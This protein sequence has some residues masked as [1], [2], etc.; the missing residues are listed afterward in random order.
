MLK[1]PNSRPA[2]RL[3]AVCARC[4]QK[5]ECGCLRSSFPLTP[6]LSRRERERRQTVS[7]NSK[8][9]RREAG[10]LDVLPLPAGEGRGEGERD[11][12]TPSAAP[13]RPTCAR[14]VS[15]RLAIAFTSA[16]LTLHTDPVFAAT[17]ASTAKPALVFCCR[18]DNDFYRAATARLGEFPRFERAADAIAQAPPHAGVCLLADDY[19][20]QRTSLNS[21]LLTAAKQKDL[22]LF[23]EFPAWLPDIEVGTPRFAEWER[24]VVTSDTFGTDLPPLRILA[25]H[26][27][28]FVP[29]PAAEPHLVLARVAGFD[30]AVFGLPKETFP[31]LFELA[32]TDTH[33]PLLIATTKLSQF[34]TA[35]YAPTDVWRPVWKMVLGWT[36]PGRELPEPAWTPTVRPSFGPSDPLPDAVEAQ[37]L[38]RGLEWFRKSKL[39]LHPSRESEILQRAQAGV[40]PCPA[41]DGPIGDGSLGILEGLLSRIGPEGRQPQTIARRG[42]CTA[43]SA[44]A[45]AFGG[46]ISG[47]PQNLN[48]AKNLLDYWYFTSIAR[49]GERGDP[50]HGAYGLI[51]WGISTPAWLVANYG[52][53]NARLLL[54][55]M[56]TAA[57]TGEARWD[58]AMLLCLLANLRTTGQLGFRDDRIDVGPLG[59]HGWK[60]FF[61]RRFTSFA[62]HYE[63]YLWAC[64]LWAWHKTGFELFRERAKTALR[65][66]MEAYPDRW[67]WTNGLQQERARMLLPLAWLVR[68]EDTPEHRAWLRRLATDLLALQDTSGALREEIGALERGQ[69]KPPQSNEQYGTGETPVLQQ[70][71]DPVCDLLYTSNF[72]FL[73][74][75]EAAAAT[76]DAFY[77]QAADKLARFLCRIQ[78]QSDAHPELDGGWFRAFDFK[79]W[80]YW[81]SNGDA[82]WGAW[83]IESG[84]T[85]GWI[86]SVLALRQMKASLWDLTADSKIARHLAALR[87]KMIP[88]EVLPK[89][90]GAAAEHRHPPD[91]SLTLIPPSPVT[92]QITLDVRAALRNRGTNAKTFD[93]AIYLDE[94]AP[95][96]L[97]HRAQV[98]VK[99]GAS[100]GLSFRFPTTGRTGSHRLR[101]V[102][103]SGA[104]T[105]HCSRP[106]EIR[107]AQTRST[108]RI[109]GAW[110]GLYHWSEQEG[111]LWNAELKQMSDAQWREL[112]RAMREVGMNVIVLGEA[113]R[114]Q[115]Y[116]GQHA[117]EKD[118]YHGKA[119]YPS[120]LF[121]DRVDIAAND[122]FEAILSEADAHGQQVFM[123][124]G[125]YAWFDFTAGSLAWHCRIADELWALY[126]HHPSFYGWYVTEEIAGNLGENEARRAELVEF[127]RAFREHVRRLAPDKPVMLASNC[128]SV[129]QGLA[130][131][132]QLLRHLDILCPFGFHRMPAGDLTGEEAAALLQRL[133]DEAG[134]H[135][136]LDLEAFLFAPDGALYPRPLDG[137]VSDLKRFP[138]FE[139]ILCYQFPGLFSAP[140]MSRKP[141]GAATVK[142]Y[143]DYQHRLGR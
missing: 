140:W 15:A 112:V 91:I 58:E 49:K 89:P 57:L 64:Y 43:E 114:N 119:F 110:A 36:C 113:F 33:G 73:G 40:A 19:P 12:R 97:L 7:D 103:R 75:H 123:P 118:G 29:V 55:T 21:A 84:W 44:M 67:R 124:V 136:W 143:E 47:D 131:Y 3:E 16:F 101:L 81:A 102:A 11:R 38:R 107:P 5:G 106:L 130:Y 13:L 71:G 133:C 129:K 70:N 30:T 68:I 104:E 83:C 139:K 141:G 25:L 109:D 37:A 27:C 52:D 61:D 2:R 48:L 99:P 63:C 18:A 115:V 108:G 46:K 4:R 62:P 31:L 72:A 98:E 10:L 82:G 51:A 92:D 80:E 105:L 137:L 23:V 117:I 100:L 17:D 45:L 79:R 65:L 94:E 66:T 14:S 138:T 59:T 86:T 121:P 32:E 142:L 88:D 96:N 90:S 50:N 120:R 35:R 125:L 42:D 76:G 127:F 41:P 60:H 111:R 20:N 53:D 126:G 22:R 39:L 85:Q 128:H 132:P 134:A 9:Q 135:L 6:A 116:V 1:P 95:A 34:V 74:L 24:A 69:L 77:S 87:P 122:P 26:N 54:G 28:S 8:H 78:I 93:A 56:A